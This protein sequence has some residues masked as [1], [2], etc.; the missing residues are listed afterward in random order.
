MSALTLLDYVKLERINRKLY[1]AQTELEPLLSGEETPMFWRE[2]FEK[3][4]R[5]DLHYCWHENADEYHQLKNNEAIVFAHDSI[6]PV[7]WRRDNW[8]DFADASEKP[9]GKN[10]C[11]WFYKL[12][13]ETARSEHLSWSKISRLGGVYCQARVLYKSDPINFYANEKILAERSRP[14]P[15]FLS[16]QL[17]KALLDE[18]RNLKQFLIDLD[19]A[20]LRQSEDTK[21]KWR[22][23]H[24]TLDVF[25]SVESPDSSDQYD[26]LHFDVTGIS[27]GKSPALDKL[28][29]EYKPTENQADEPCSF[30]YQILRSKKILAGT[31]AHNNY[32][33]KFNVKAQAKSDMLIKFEYEDIIGTINHK[34]IT[35]VN[36]ENHASND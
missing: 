26:Y 22:N 36:G 23:Y 17:N 29:Y 25:V 6:Y 1:E 14:G 16:A 4:A 24:L 13:A 8:N 18:E 5:F 11:Y 21:Y 28:G 7:P 32:L 35:S 33:F 12:Y 10:H 20:W 27:Q 31:D 3:S 15:R 30:F 9:G 34:P 19:Q 2:R